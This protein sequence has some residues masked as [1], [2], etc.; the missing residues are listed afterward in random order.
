MRYLGVDYGTKRVGVALSDE[1]G[2]F[3]FP[4]GTLIRDEKILENIGSIARREKVE[5]IVVGDARALSGAANELTPEAESFA[6]ELEA[7]TRLPVFRAREAWS[8][9]EAARFAPKGKKHD[10]SAAAA[11]ILQRFLDTRKK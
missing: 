6:R 2:A 4:H 3:A 7:R 11:I 8:S 5:A 1:A 9:R 10:D